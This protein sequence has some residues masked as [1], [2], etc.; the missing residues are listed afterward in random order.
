MFIGS[1]VTA[2]LDVSLLWMDVSSNYEC[3]ESSCG[4]QTVGGPLARGLGGGHTSSP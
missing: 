4:Q 1:L 2:A 3:T